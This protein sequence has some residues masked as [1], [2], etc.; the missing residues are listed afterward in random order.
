[1]GLSRCGIAEDEWWLMVDHRSDFWSCGL[2]RVSD[3]SRGDP[4]GSLLPYERADEIL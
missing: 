4:E 1:M 2:T 3:C